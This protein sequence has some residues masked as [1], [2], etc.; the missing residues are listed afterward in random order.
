MKVEKR[1]PG[2]DRAGRERW[3]CSV[4]LS[5]CTTSSKEKASPR[6]GTVP[7]YV[8]IVPCKGKRN[9]TLEISPT[10]QKGPELRALEQW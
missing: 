9:S 6:E 2:G 4:L 3:R 7:W 5:G 8:F 10:F 1:L